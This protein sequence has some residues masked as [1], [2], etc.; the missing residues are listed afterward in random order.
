MELAY[1]PF[2]LQFGVVAQF[3]GNT[4]GLRLHCASF[5]VELYYRISGICMLLCFIICNG[6]AGD[7]LLVIQVTSVGTMIKVVVRE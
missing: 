5:G 4:N 2:Y 3:V 1:V 6:I 7:T